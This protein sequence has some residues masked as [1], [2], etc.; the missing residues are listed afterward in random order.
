MAIHG[1]LAIVGLS[2]IRETSVFNDIPIAARRDELRCG[3]AI[4]HLKSRQ[5]IATLEFKSGVE[6]VFDVQVVPG[7]RCPAIIGPHCEK[8]GMPSTWVVP[9]PSAD[10]K[11]RDGHAI[12]AAN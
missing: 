4:V 10:A 3:L 7:S 12:G 6:E 8:D 9:Q 1:G 5:T 11:A 2:R